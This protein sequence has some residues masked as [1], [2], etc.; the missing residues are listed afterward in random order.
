MSDKGI[1]DYYKGVAE[2]DALERERG[3]YSLSSFSGGLHVV[4]NTEELKENEVV[5]VDGFLSFKGLWTK[6]FELV[7]DTNQV[8]DNINLALD[9]SLPVC[10]SS[11]EV[12]EYGDWDIWIEYYASFASW[13]EYN[14]EDDPDKRSYLSW[15][16]GTISTIDQGVTKI[17]TVV[18]MTG[19]TTWTCNLG[20]YTGSLSYTPI[21]RDRLEVITDDSAEGSFVVTVKD[22]YKTITRTVSVNAMT[23]N[24]E[25]PDEEMTP[26][27]VYLISVKNSHLFFESVRY[28]DWYVDTT[29]FYQDDDDPASKAVNGVYLVGLTDKEKVGPYVLNEAIIMTTEGEGGTVTIKCEDE[30]T[31]LE[32]EITVTSPYELEF[33]FSNLPESYWGETITGYSLT[34]ILNSSPTVEYNKTRYGTVAPEYRFYA[35][36]DDYTTWSE[37][38]LEEDP[39]NYHVYQQWTINIRQYYGVDQTIFDSGVKLI[40]TFYNEYGVYHHY[41]EYFTNCAVGT[42]VVIFSSSYEVMDGISTA[43]FSGTLTSNLYLN[44]ELYDTKVT[45]YTNGV[46]TGTRITQSTSNY[47]DSENYAVKIR[48]SING[49]SDEYQWEGKIAGIEFNFNITYTQYVSTYNYAYLGIK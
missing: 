25:P 37:G 36:A 4:E 48:T 1:L 15:A 14:E 39:L 20:S 18:K 38:N 42:P 29:Q 24:K 7:S 9:T 23:W 12:I 19:K 3:E 17:L 47:Y 49:V 44:K 6:D 43:Q 2:E 41:E 40:K 32:K 35:T 30:D 26:G 45:I 8:V 10:D 11:S 5:S 33:Y 34:S 21:K 27:D 13:G 22:S 28:P 31:T 46:A 16:T